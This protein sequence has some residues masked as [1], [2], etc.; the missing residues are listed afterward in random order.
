VDSTEDIED[1][2]SFGRRKCMDFP[3]MTVVVKKVRRCLTVTL[4]GRTIT[5]ITCQMSELGDR[6]EETFTIQIM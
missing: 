5:A 4:R 2:E 1:F 3:L 6:R